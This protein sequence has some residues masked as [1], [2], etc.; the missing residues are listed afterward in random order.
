ML[1]SGILDFAIG[2]VFTFLAVSLAAGAAT[3]TIASALKWR[4]HTL[5]KG[6][7]SLLND[8]QG[9]EL[10]AALYKHGLINPRSDGSKASS[11]RTNPAYIDPKQF[12]VAFLEIIKGLPDP[13]DGNEQPAGQRVAGQ[14]QGVAGQQQGAAG[15]QQGLAGQQQG[16]AGQQQGLAGQQQGA[17]GQQQG[18]AGQQQGA[19]GQQQPEAVGQLK[20]QIAKLRGDDSGQLKSMLNGIVERARGDETAIRTELSTWFDNSMDRVSGAYKRWAQLWSFVLALAIAAILNVST[21]D[22]AKSLWKQPVDTKLIAASTAQNPPADYLTTLDTLPIG[23]PSPGANPGA[24]KSSPATLRGLPPDSMPQIG[25]ASHAA[26]AASADTSANVFGFFWRSP[27]EWNWSRIGGWLITAFATLFGAPF[28]FD[29]LQQLVRL[30]GS[31]P[32]PAEKKAHTAA[33][34]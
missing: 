30:K 17:A 7:K 20:V 6:I 9:N 4:S 22:I 23:W 31:G 33:S 21:I 32:S 1:G 19:A 29:A 10:A 3:E 16:A 2:L 12:A 15:Q 26:P 18:A 11:W 14:Q 5:L 27:A 24:P 25:A 13:L 34:T 28:W 8:P